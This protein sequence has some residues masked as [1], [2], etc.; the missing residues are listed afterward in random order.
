[1]K[2]KFAGGVS[3]LAN[4]LDV[5]A[6]GFQLVRDFELGDVRQKPPY[7]NLNSAFRRRGYSMELGVVFVEKLLNDSKRVR[8]D[9]VEF[10]GVVWTGSSLD[11]VSWN[12]GY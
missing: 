10:N 7:D 2:R 1:M 3:E 12:D 8:V 11:A 9:T 6:F 4:C 5:I